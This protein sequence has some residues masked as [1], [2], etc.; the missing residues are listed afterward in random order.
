MKHLTL[1]LFSVLLLSAQAH[2]PRI[3]I[4][5]ISHE[6][7]SFNPAKTGIADFV[8]RRNRPIDAALRE[9]AKSNDIV[10]GYVE[11]GR[12]YGL[13]LYPTMVA[14]AMPEGPVTDEALNKLTA[15]LIRQLKAAP[16]LDGLLLDLHGAMFVESYPVGDA[17]VVR[18]LREVFPAPFPIVVTHDFHANVSPEIV[19]LSTVLITYKEDPHLDTH[20]RGLQ[21][22]EVMAKIVSG[23]VK[24]VQAIVKPP[25]L[26]NIVYQNT[27]AAPL[28]PIVDESKRLEKN[29]KILAVSVSG[30]YQYADSPALGPSVVVATDNDPALAQKEAQ[31]LADMLWATRDRLVLNLPDAAEGVRRAMAGDKFPAVLVDMGDNIGGGSP[32]DSTFVLSE[33]VRQKAQGWVVVIADP[34]AVQAAAR[35]GINTAF[36]QLV[37]GK[38][39]KMH[40]A[41]VRVRGRVK[42]LHDGRWVELE[43][44]HGG[45]R[46]YDQGLTAVIEADGST[47]DLQNLLMLTTKR[48]VPFSLGQL[49]SCGIYPKRQK[50][51]AVKAAIAY[52]AAYEPIAA[53][54]IELDTPGVTAVNPAR[55]KYTRVRRPMFGLDQP[56]LSSR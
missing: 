35:A 33:L 46:Y 24:P 20:E 36:D 30:G 12:R 14:Q 11:G 5:G 4:G 51:L 8:V 48:Q 28:K 18:R 37:G 10:S 39:D 56:G 29:P 23:K 45:Q 3:A 50:I 54:I 13:D 40:G 17:E 53:R 47:P 9:W 27:F 16:K 25:M 22:A 55:F 34:Q 43:V 44:R 6:S 7:D 49:T 42:S 32:G 38:T 21:A 1:F 2:R 15:E 26:Y 31:R 52:R 41:P 19:K